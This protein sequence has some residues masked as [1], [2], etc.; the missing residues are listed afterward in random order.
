[1]KSFKRFHIIIDE[2][3]VIKS[4]MLDVTQIENL[5]ENYAYFF[6]EIII[7]KNMTNM[8]N[9]LISLHNKLSFLETFIIIYLL[10]PYVIIII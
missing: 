1:M 9:K 5:R 4:Y 6:K 3:Q 10:I 7:I 8:A 2:T